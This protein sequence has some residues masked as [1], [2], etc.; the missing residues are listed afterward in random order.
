MYQ[1]ND[2]KGKKFFKSVLIFHLLQIIVKNTFINFYS[3][4]SISLPDTLTSL[5]GCCFFSC[6]S[7]QQINLPSS[8]KELSSHCFCSCSNLSFVYIPKSVKALVQNPF[9]NCYKLFEIISNEKPKIEIEERSI[10]KIEISEEN[11]RKQYAI[12]EKNVCLNYY[13]ICSQDSNKADLFPYLH[14]F[15]QYEHWIF[16]SSDFDVAS[17]EIQTAP[18]KTIFIILDNSIN[19][20]YIDDSAKRGIVQGNNVLKSVLIFHPLKILENGCFCRYSSLQSI[21]LSNTLTSLGD[22]CFS[23][24]SSLQSIFFPN[25]LTSFGNQCFSDCSF[26]QSVSLPQNMKKISKRCFWDCKIFLIFF[27]FLFSFFFGLFLF[28]L[29]IF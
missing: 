11:E 18:N 26:L 22:L 27:F 8:L 1:T 15:I 14:Q 6:R 12:K 20:I 17:F 13:F 24:C 5:G 28:F 29:L 19:E 9:E 2:E 7:L 21:S 23:F 3:L 10:F 25:S 4:Q 16:V